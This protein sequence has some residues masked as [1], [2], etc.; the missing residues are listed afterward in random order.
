MNI[1]QVLFYEPT[2][3]LLIFF[4][5]LF[6]ENLGLS[7]LVLA[8]LT[9][10]VTYPLTRRQIKSAE[11]NQEFQKRMTEVKKKFKHNE[12][13]QAKELAKIQAEFLPAQLG[14]CLNI[15]IS[16]IFLIQVRNVVVNLVNEGTHAFNEVAYAES[17]KLA[18]DSVTVALPADFAEGEHDLSVTIGASNDALMTQE[19][20]FIVAVAGAD[21]KELQKTIDAYYKE[22]PEDEQKQIQADLRAAN[23]GV[24]IPEF[25]KQAIIDAGSTEL[26]LYFRPPSNETIDYDTLEIK[27]DETVIAVEQLQ[28]TQGKP[29]N[30]EFLGADLSRVATDYGFDK[31]GPVLPYIVIALLMGITQ[32]G[33]SKIQMGLN[34][35]TQL[36]E[37][38]K[39]LRQAQGKDKPAKKSKDKPEEPDFAELMAQSSKNM[40]YFFPFLTV[41]MSLGVLGG[42]SFFPTGVSLFWT[43]QNTFVIIQQ[44]L[45]NRKKIWSKFVAWSEK[46]TL[47]H[48]AKQQAPELVEVVERKREKKRKKKK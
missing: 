8:L 18:E 41:A 44:L 48:E 45:E 19:F 22:L 6:A 9:R 36:K 31:I 10:L 26:K 7:I 5:N 46:R 2:F 3:N 23:I 24:Y 42:G 30:L 39:T 11:K 1:F 13:Q 35:T 38:E 28:T 47:I 40:V 27:I 17:M 33:A 43:G 37:D 12:E 21:A 32:F 14:G 29:F 34:P 4:Y 16:L 25:K 20:R 15:I